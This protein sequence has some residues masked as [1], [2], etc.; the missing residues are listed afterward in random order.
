MD[1]AAPGLH[2]SQPKL[3]A[4]SGTG[5]ELETYPDMPWTHTERKAEFFNLQ[6]H[7][8][9]AALRH[10]LRAFW[11]PPRVRVFF[12]NRHIHTTRGDDGGALDA[13]NYA[14]AL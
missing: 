5:S 13:P 10:A 3:A 7:R 11:S 2:S 9:A 4:V 8:A 1:A 12:L 6:N 14:S